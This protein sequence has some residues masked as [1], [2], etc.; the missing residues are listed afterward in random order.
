MCVMMKTPER[1]DWK[2]CVS[3]HDESEKAADAFKAAFA[4]HQQQE[5]P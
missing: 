4:K 3:S 1:V 2:Q 5:L